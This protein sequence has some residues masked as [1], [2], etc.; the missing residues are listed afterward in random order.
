MARCCRGGPCTGWLRLGSCGPPS[1]QGW[2]RAERV[3]LAPVKP[4]AA[5]AVVLAH[6]PFNEPEAMGP[7]AV[8]GLAGSSTLL[9]APEPE[10]DHAGQA[11]NE[12]APAQERRHVVGVTSIGPVESGEVGLV[13]AAQLDPHRARLCVQGVAGPVEQLRCGAVVLRD[14]DG[15]GASGRR[16]RPSF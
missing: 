13:D 7:A 11:G 3:L 8:N 9:A 5:W 4:A 14:P 12:I 1:G 10:R 2:V 15:P 16:M 6:V